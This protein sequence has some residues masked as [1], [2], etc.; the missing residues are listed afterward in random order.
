MPR[1]HREVLD[2]VLR[3]D[4]LRML[5]QPVVDLRD[6]RLV[7][8]EALARGPR[9]TALEAPTALF[10]VA[11][12]EGRLAE[13]DWA[14]RA[15]AFRCSLDAE[16]R[17]GWR[18]FVNAE[19]QTLNTAC[20]LPL[21]RHW[22][23]A[24]RELDVVVEVTERALLQRPGDLVRVVSTLRELGWEIA[25]DD[26]GA[27][28][29]SVALLPVLAPDVVKL[30]GPLLAARLSRP[31]ARALRAVTGY[32]ERSGAVLLA[33]GIESEQDLARARELGAVWGQGFLLGRPRPLAASAAA[34]AGAPLRQVRGD[35]WD[36][37]PDTDVFAQLAGALPRLVVDV[38]ALTRRLEAVC[39][40]AGTSA[41]AGVLLL[42]VGEGVAVPAALLRL[43]DGL[44]RAC[45]LVSLQTAQD[46][47][48][49]LSGVRLSRLADA[50]RAAR[51]QVTAAFVSPTSCTALSAQRRPD[52]RFE[53]VAG[54][55][56]EEVAA[57]A[58][59][60][61]SRVPGLG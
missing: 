15:E 56:P 5:F 54:D 55:D 8:H 45:T 40:R 46:L 42:S 29:A 51:D 61:L 39:V 11:R 2:D 16:V 44:A 28:D 20:P 7:G 23:R 19:P 59:L 58:R 34:A 49:R 18:L 17:R 9:G 41:H 53:V 26:A 12:A 3:A 43:L 24:H 37:L 27:N 47:P 1:P 30:D 10:D 25:L 22:Q 4:G 48:S 32:A 31:Q 60:L 57:L 36:L 14:C 38:D 13:L 21:L 33:E 52:G 35:R 6:G 50:G